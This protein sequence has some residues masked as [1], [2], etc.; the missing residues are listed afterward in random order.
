MESVDKIKEFVQIRSGSG[1]GYGYGDGD[2]S[3]SGDGYGDGDGSLYIAKINGDKVYNIDNVPTIVKSVKNNIAKGFVVNNDL[4]LKPCY[5][6]KSENL[7][8]HGE[9]LKEAYM[10][11]Q[12]KLL[13]DM[14]V[15]DRIEKFL[16]EFKPNT[17]YSNKLFF[18]WHHILTGSC[19]FGRQQFCK[20]K[21]IDLDGETTVEEFIALTEGDYGGEVIKRLKERLKEVQI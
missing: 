18:D 7:F 6:V 10:A 2:G 15:E 13:K 9:T 3:G 4:T 5:I 14:P 16:Q 11:L 8:A 12:K 21:G 17:K 20:N 19:L 1:Y